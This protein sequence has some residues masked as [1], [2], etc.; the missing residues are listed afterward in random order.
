VA[1]FENARDEGRSF[2]LDS[3]NQAQTKAQRRLRRSLGVREEP[4]IACMDPEE[5]YMPIGGG[6]RQLHGDLASML[7]GGLGSL[8]LQ[9]L[10]PYAMT[11]VAQHSMYKE[12]P[13]RRLEQTAMFIGVTTYGSRKDALATIE[14]VRAVH[15]V[16][17]GTARDGVTYSANDPRLLE[18]VH[19]AEVWMFLAGAKAYGPSPISNELADAYVNEMATLARDLGVLDPP[20]TVRGLKVR[21]EKFRPELELIPEGR[22]ARN[23]VMRGVARSPQE[24]LAYATLIAGSVG[25]LPSWARR[26]LGIP[27]LPL[28]NTLLVRP[29][30]TLLCTSLRF[31]VPPARDHSTSER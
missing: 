12:A 29:A 21:L 13:L 8:L 16:V 28:A 27:K 17:K 2:V 30:A 23:F 25:L 9:M 22:E 26:G 19:V 24:R 10:H 4:P 14:K 11:G 5:S 20:T 7:I 18:W 31:V 6:A 1:T 15:K 3:M